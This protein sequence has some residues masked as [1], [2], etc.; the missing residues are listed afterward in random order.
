MTGAYKPWHQK[1]L[2][3]N[4]RL[5]MGW[6]EGYTF[7]RVIGVEVTRQIGFVESA[8]IT[9]AM[10]PAGAVDD[11]SNRQSVVI[12]DTD[13]NYHEDVTSSYKSN[14]ILQNFYGFNPPW[15]RIFISYPADRRMGKIL[16]YPSP[17]P[18]TR[19]GFITGEDSPAE[20]PT[21][22]AEFFF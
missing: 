18:D 11:P 13:G 21:D 7:H 12:R 17:T 4:W 5:A 16:S 10:M 19:Y 14:I 20:E 3:Q 22:A 1:V 6:E 8:A 15:L 9:S 2:Q